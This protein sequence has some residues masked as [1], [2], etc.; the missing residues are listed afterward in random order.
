VLLTIT[1]TVRPAT[2][3]G[4]LLVKHPQRVQ[5]FAQ[6]FGTAHVFYPDA[7]PDRC[8]AA[9]LL[10]VDPMKLA[11]ARKTP[12]LSLGQYVNDRPYAASSL[13]AS[14]MANVFRTAMRGASRD[15]AELAATAIPLTITLPALPC[16]GGVDA[17]HRLFEP[18]GWRV[19]ARAIP[20]DPE[21][22]QWGD[23]RYVTLTIEGELKL[24][25][26]LNQVYV[27]LPVL[28]DSKHYWV[29]SDEVDKLIRA[30]EGWLAAHP[31]RGRIT[32]R[33]LANRRGLVRTALAR[34]ADADD[35]PD[36]ALDRDPI[37]EEPPTSDPTAAEPVD[38][39]TEAAAPPVPLAERRIQ[40]VLDVLR[41]EEAHRVI[42][43][44]CGSGKLLSRLLQD[45]YFGSVAGADVSPRAIM[46]AQRWLEPARLTRAQEERLSLFT[47][48]L[49]YAD[50]RFHG[51]DAAV[52]M[53]VIEHVDVPRLPAVERVVFGDARPRVVVVTT[54]NAEYNVRY[55]GL[56]GFRHP[57]HRFEWTRAEF[58]EWAEKVAAAYGYQVRYVPVG[59]DDA[60]V[61]PPTQMG[62][63]NR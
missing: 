30:G 21:F 25:D 23:S 40:A 32:R 5:T 13:L 57:D 42:D 50:D 54:P 7:S 4:Y 35:R 28:D 51:Y 20:L 1:T 34:L 52:L 14:A 41:A 9:L 18:L 22:P 11:K 2:D 3:L 8:T 31:E 36:D 55:E 39:E 17:A 16:R 59:D 46:I 29:A 62:V 33:Y 37:D 48:A 61:G 6:S 10:D 56:T 15:R 53:E 45:P 27:L 44:G 60:E 19:T 24:S 58:R 43:L 49:T 26:A 47:G 12:D 38:A 63:F